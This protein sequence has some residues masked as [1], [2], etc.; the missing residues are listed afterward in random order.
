MRRLLWALALVAFAA[1]GDDGGELGDVDA[2]IVAPRPH[3]DDSCF[4][5]VSYDEVHGWELWAMP[6]GVDGEAEYR[7]LE[8]ADAAS[9]CATACEWEARHCGGARETC[10]VWPSGEPARCIDG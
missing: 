10:G 9:A 8:G 4:A 7:A 3:D 6:D 5:A 1:C 2:A